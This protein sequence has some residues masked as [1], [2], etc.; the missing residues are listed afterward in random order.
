MNRENNVRIDN[1]S[2]VWHVKKV[3]LREDKRSA[4]LIGN[5]LAEKSH[6]NS[7]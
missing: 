6:L 4:D 1:I 5:A 2:E 7:N 3:A